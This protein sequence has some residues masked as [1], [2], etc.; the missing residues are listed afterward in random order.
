MHNLS[1]YLL[2]RRIGILRRYFLMLAYILSYHRLLVNQ[3]IEQI[4]VEQIFDF[5]VDTEYNL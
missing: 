2:D 1:C 3:I 5:G 4:F